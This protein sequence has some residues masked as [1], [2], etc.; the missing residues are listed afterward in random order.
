M[1]FLKKIYLLL[2]H[3]N[4]LIATAAMAQ[5]ALTYYVFGAPLNY[6]IILIEGAA[7]VLLYNTSILLARPA[8]PQASPYLR[9]RWFFQH[10]P[11]VWGTN[12]VALLL[13]I[14]GLTQIHLI[15]FLCLG[16][17]GLCS[18][19]YHIPMLYIDGKWTGFRQIPLFKIFHIALVW[20]LSSVFLPF[21]ELYV[22]GTSIS[23]TLLSTLASLKF[24]FLL[25]C[26][27]PFDIRDI[28]QDSYY[29]LKTIPSMLGEARAIRLCYFLLVMHSVL[30]VLAP[31]LLAVKV[32]LLV[33]NGVILLLLKK[34]VFKEQGHYH[35]AYLLDCCLIIQFIAVWLFLKTPI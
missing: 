3:T 27:L 6:A 1:T 5:C 22:R 17:I 24:I 34:L 31:Y 28:R 21:I 33:T 30:L 23:I 26:T 25:I 20:T 18:I 13:L 16:L 29:H 14:Y 35:Y 8:H 11:L 12:A 4:W 2:V 32:G 15:S 10:L 9:T 7:T 19:L